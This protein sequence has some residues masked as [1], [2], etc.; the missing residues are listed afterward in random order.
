MGKRGVFDI[1][2]ERIR[3]GA[4]VRA[5]VWDKTGGQCWY[6]GMQTN[7][8]RDFC[9]DHLVALVNGGSNDLRNLVP[10]C[11]ACNAEKGTLSLNE[12]R[13]ARGGKALRFRLEMFS[14]D[15]RFDFDTTEIP[16]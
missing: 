6:C 10:C 11:R 2:R 15:T 4:E 14:V 3:F 5:E 9:V 16:R 12:F 7:P 13:E 1:M 8:F